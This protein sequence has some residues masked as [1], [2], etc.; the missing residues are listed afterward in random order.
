MKRGSSGGASVAPLLKENPANSSAVAGKCGESRRTAKTL[1][2][3]THGIA[4]TLV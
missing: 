3:L 1:H 4:D 2:A